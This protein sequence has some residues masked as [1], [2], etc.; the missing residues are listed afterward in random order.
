MRSG[1]S[2]STRNSRGRPQQQQQQQQQI[3][4]TNSQGEEIP[5]H[6]LANRVDLSGDTDDS[7][8]NRTYSSGSSEGDETGLVSM[9]GTESMGEHSGSASRSS[10]M[11][12]AHR[13]NS[14]GDMRT[15]S[16]ASARDYRSEDEVQMGQHQQSQPQYRAGMT[17]NAGVSYGA[18]LHVYPADSAAKPEATT[19]ALASTG[20]K[21]KKSARDLMRLQAGKANLVGTGSNT[22]TTSTATARYAG[23]VSVTP[24]PSHRRVRSSPQERYDDYNDP[25]VEPLPSPESSPSSSPLGLRQTKSVDF[26]SG[27]EGRG[28]GTKSPH[29]HMA[30]PVTSSRQDR[31]QKHVERQ[32]MLGQTSR[33]V[34]NIEPSGASLPASSQP[35]SQGSDTSAPSRRDFTMLASSNPA[36]ALNVSRDGPHATIV[37]LRRQLDETLAQN[38][39]S[40]TSLARSDA[41]ILE[42]RR[43]LRETSGQLTKAEGEREL[44]DRRATELE[45]DLSTSQQ[46][47]HELRV[48][49]QARSKELERISDEVGRANQRDAVL[50][51]LQLKLDRAEAQILTADMRNKQL[52]EDYRSDREEWE[53][54]LARKEDE[55]DQCRAELS[56]EVSN[57]KDAEQFWRESANVR[58]E[59]MRELESEI[60]RLSGMLRET[61]EREAAIQSEREADREALAEVDELRGDLDEAAKVVDETRIALNDALDE[62]AKARKDKDRAECDRDF[63]REELD[64]LTTKLEQEMSEK[65]QLSKERN[66]LREENAGLRSG[67]GINQSLATNN[68]DKVGELSRQLSSA[69]EEAQHLRA[70]LSTV[71]AQAAGTPDKASLVRSQMEKAEVGK[72]KR[73]LEAKNARLESRLSRILAERDNL[74]ECLDD[75]MNELEIADAGTLFRLNEFFSLFSHWVY[76][77]LTHYIITAIPF[78]Q[79]HYYFSNHAQRQRMCL[80]I[81]GST[82]NWTARSGTSMPSLFSVILK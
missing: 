82:P 28:G 22:Y 63:A 58:E 79:R 5:S 46:E 50:G 8:R 37:K 33:A 20:S 77:H 54:N 81:K 14:R 45:Q 9:S 71:E 12:R 30:A 2:R 16:K 18:G 6:H 64:I 39:R 78:S 19:P 68:E 40:K 73:E 66:V 13:L 32:K 47:L 15:M 65:D 62:L 48:T 75:A 56:G 25:E 4:R 49:V 23:A 10:G 76:A 31:L 57:R 35:R 52:E 70:R 29:M 38:E 51:E 55:L 36:T 69:K 41:V 74:K 21:P 26:E 17:N 53:M 61:N 7:H 60:A 27:G 44:L 42:L 34:H 43:D 59:R 1:G 24:S 3:K 67:R 72:V 11:A 80:N